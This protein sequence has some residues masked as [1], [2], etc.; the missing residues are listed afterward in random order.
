MRR[1]ATMRQPA[2]GLE[3]AVLEQL[4]R[5]WGAVGVGHNLVILAVNDQHRYADLLQVFGE[6]GFRKYLM[7]SYPAL[8]PPII[9][10]RHQLRIKASMGFTPG[11]LKL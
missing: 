11:R 5:H 1:H 8:A 4:H 9:P 3:R 2:V 7:Q 6:V 10:C